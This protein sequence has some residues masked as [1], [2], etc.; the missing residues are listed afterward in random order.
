MKTTINKINVNS[1]SHAAI[2]ILHLFK[3]VI[4]IKHVL[5]SIEKHRQQSVIVF[6]FKQFLRA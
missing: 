1:N 2:N 5:S 6:I 3:I 4:K